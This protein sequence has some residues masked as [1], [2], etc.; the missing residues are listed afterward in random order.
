MIYGDALE[1]ARDVFLAT[2]CVATDADGS[3]EQYSWELG[4]GATADTAEASHAYKDPGKYQIRLTVTDDGRGIR[5]GVDAPSL[6][7]HNHFG[8]AGMYERDITLH[9]W[10]KVEKDWQ[11]NFWFLK[12]LGYQG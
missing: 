7:A 2:K 3:I 9:L 4:D 8:L 12:K 11:K 5:G 1:S 10:V 6:I